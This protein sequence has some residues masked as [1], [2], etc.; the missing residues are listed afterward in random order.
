M[1]IINLFATAREAF[2]E[3]R[4]RSRAYS[5]LMSLDDRSL[6][7][8]GVDRSEIPSLVYGR[9]TAE[10]EPAY[11]SERGLDTGIFAAHQ[12]RLAGGRGA[13]PPL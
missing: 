9:Q 11:G 1:F 4:R 2:S 12:A 10:R 5:E 8:I 6:S 7:D 3:W 13:M